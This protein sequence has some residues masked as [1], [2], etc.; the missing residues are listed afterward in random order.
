MSPVYS[1]MVMEHFK[2]PRNVGTM[3]KPDGIGFIGDP[4]WGIDIELYINVREGTIVDARFKTFGCGATIA[5]TSMVTEM[6]KGKSIAEALGISKEVI[7]Q[8]LG[9]LPEAKMH[10]P[11]LA[12]QALKL[13]IKDYLNKNNGTKLGG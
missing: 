10:C 9:G 8:A 6:A 13:A 2:N 1:E 4:S 5:T 12:E 7:V 11:S 3:D